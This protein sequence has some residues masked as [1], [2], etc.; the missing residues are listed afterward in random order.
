MPTLRD[1]IEAMTVRD[2]DITYTIINPTTD[3]SDRKVSF[4]NLLR[5]RTG[6]VSVDALGALGNGTA[7]DS[8]IINTAIA[9]AAASGFAVL[10]TSGKTYGIG[11]S[12]DGSY[13]N[14]KFICPG[15]GAKL[16]KLDTGGTS[17]IIAN[18]G[19]NAYKGWSFDGVEFDG[20]GVAIQSLTVV[21][22]D[23]SDVKFLRCKFR[24]LTGSLTLQAA[25]RIRF[26]DCTLYGTRPGL[27]ASGT[28]DPAAVSNA[29]YTSGIQI[30]GG[31]NDITVENCR[32]HFVNGCVAQSGVETA[33]TQNFTVRNNRFR[34][35]YW[36]GPYARLRFT[37]TAYNSG[38]RVATVAA[39]GLT[40]HF[41]TGPAPNTV[42]IAVQKGSGSNLSGFAGQM[43]TTGSFGSVRTGD[44]IETVN[45]KRAEII[46]VTD[47]QHVQISEWEAM[48]TFE[49]TSAPA[50]NTSW[51]VMRYFAASAQIVDDTHLSFYFEPVNV[52]TGEL[53]TNGAS[54]VTTW[55]CRELPNIGYSGLHCNWGSENMIVEGNTFRGS[56]ADQLSV[57]HTE[58]ARLIGNTI[59]YGQ[60]QGITLTHSLRAA[61]IG[62][63]F[64]YAGVSGISINQ[65]HHSTLIGNVIDSW[66]IVNRGFE[67]RGAIQSEGPHTGLIIEGNTGSYNET[68]GFGGQSPYLVSLI[69]GSVPSTIISNNVGQSRVG[70]LYVDADAVVSGVIAHGVGVI[71]GPG[72]SSGNI[73]ALKTITPI[74]LGTTTPV[75]AALLELRSRNDSNTLFAILDLAGNVKLSFLSTSLN[76]TAIP[77][78]SLA[79]G[80]SPILAFRSSYW[81]GSASVN[82]LL[83][84]GTARLGGGAGNFAGH[85]TDHDGVVM[86]SLA[87]KGG[88]VA[89]GYAFASNANLGTLGQLHARSLAT[90][91]PT[92]TLQ[93]KASQMANILNFLDENSATLSAVRKDGSWQPPS[94]AD[95][96]AA[97]NSVYFSTTQSKLV[98]KD[99]GGTVNNLY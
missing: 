97:N 31:C 50:A 40:G 53:I 12:L 90:G 89:I 81:N 18:V 24:H 99:S 60:D 41:P 88:Q 48:D 14:I 23:T 19:G 57:F 15:G 28:Y 36:N 16:L 38:T 34:G 71:G 27:M 58:G 13:H 79:D 77:A 93:R 82:E 33:H 63:T 61:A 78:T 95:S 10:L 29:D 92:A 55:N 8:T 94:M 74:L 56:W 4:G 5:P 54:D 35:D 52:F 46:S 21:L 6:V 87:G 69:N 1:Q 75:T 73:Y 43:A 86:M 32:G 91:T 22:T 49:P 51:R 26:D 42:S 68:T 11:A 45:G 47:S 37:I 44:V 20:N 9:A 85:F 3:P 83:S 30:N 2:T 7:N 72:A 76:L 80:N 96:A 17:S 65:S 62:N 98:Y 25:N 67:G 84:F 59:E 70:D 39:G 64:R 66:G